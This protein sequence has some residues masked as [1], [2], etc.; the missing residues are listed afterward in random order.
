MEELCS[1]SF[2]VG[3]ELQKLIILA[4]QF[5]SCERLISLSNESSN[6]LI[7]DLQSYIIALET[8]SDIQSKVVFE[9]MYRFQHSFIEMVL[10]AMVC[11]YNQET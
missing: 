7:S 10:K 4:D 1:T 11:Y 8:N 5:Q 2:A 9:K 6:K 3:K